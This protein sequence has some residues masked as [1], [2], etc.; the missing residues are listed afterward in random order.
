MLSDAEERNTEVPLIRCSESAVDLMNTGKGSD[1]SSR[2]ARISC[3]PRAQVVSTVK[4]IAAMSNGNQ[5]PSGIF[6]RFEAK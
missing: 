5:P 2:R 1:V 4:M 3:R 6:V